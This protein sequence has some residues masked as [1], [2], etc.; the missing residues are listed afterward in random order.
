[1]RPLHDAASWPPPASCY[2]LTMTNNVI[3][4]V[5]ISADKLYYR[6][7]IYWHN[8]AQTICY[9]VVCEADLTVLTFIAIVCNT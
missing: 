4:N 2:P 6:G 8:E 3:D 1:M 5:R 7:W 9:V